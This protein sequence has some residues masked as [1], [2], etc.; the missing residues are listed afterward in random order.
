[1]PGGWFGHCLSSVSVIVVTAAIMFAIDVE[2][3]AEEGFVEEDFV[4][5]ASEEEFEES[6]VE[7]GFEE[8][9]AVEEDGGDWSL[10]FSGNVTLDSRLFLKKPLYPG[11]ERHQFGLSF[12]P[13]IYFEHID[14]A[15]FTLV[16]YFRF[17]SIDGELLD[18]DVREAYFLKYGFVDELEWELR[19]GIDRVF[20]GTAESNH[21]V[22][23]VNQTDL[24]SD[25]SGDEKLGQPM[26]QG[27]LA[28]EW[29]TLNLLALPFHRPREFPS[30]GGRLRPGWPI[31]SAGNRINY[32]HK[33]GDRHVDFAARYSHTVGLLDFGISGF[34]GTSREP[35]LSPLVTAD[36]PIL[37]QNYNQ[38]EQIG[39]DLQLTLDDFIG[40]AEIINRNGFAPIAPHKNH[41]AFVVGGEYSIN[42]IFDSDADLTLFG[43]WSRDDRGK[44]ATTPL[45]NDLF[46]AA[47]YTFNDTEDTSITA[48]VIGDLDSNSKTMNLKFSRRLSDSLSLEVEAQGFLQTDIRD[49]QLWQF[50]NDQFVEV[51]LTYGF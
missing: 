20:W 49:T 44:H 38:I 14:G 17:S 29:G 13:N 3:T 50:R 27:T 5:A 34:K 7:D 47:R 43:E 46:L 30:V 12:E 1:M 4:V 26:V 24:V 37:V 51:N 21:L 6:F 33:S 48:A 22:N 10:D 39:L 19:V 42:G 41:S 8:D 40:K 16:P 45:Q 18:V 25:P 15:S 31:S 23:I 11:Q 36:G 9:F 2:A 35:F 28:G 32:E